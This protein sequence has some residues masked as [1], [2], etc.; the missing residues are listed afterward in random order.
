MVERRVGS[1]SQVS[2][3]VKWRTNGPP[4]VRNEYA[5]PPSSHRYIRTGPIDVI[6]H[7]T[8]NLYFR[9]FSMIYE[10]QIKNRILKQMRQK[11]LFLSIALA[12]S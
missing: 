7:A 6:C 3:C 9:S 1:V 12:L 2:L 4:I 10:C 8:L 11:N 5:P